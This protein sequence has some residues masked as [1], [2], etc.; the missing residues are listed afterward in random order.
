MSQSPAAAPTQYIVRKRK[1]QVAHIW[2]GDDT[3][4]RMAST[5]GLDPANYSVV[6]E[7]GLPVCAMCKAS[8]T[9]HVP[10]AAGS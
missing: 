1:P 7:P 9:G 6:L 5:G 8:A 4:C 2:A 10:G 3:R